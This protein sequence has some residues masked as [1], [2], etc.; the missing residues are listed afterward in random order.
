MNLLPAKQPDY[1]LMATI[2]ILLSF[3][4]IMVFSSSYIMAYKW[5]GDSFYFFN[6]QLFSALI[7]LAVFFITMKIDY[8]FW[9]KFAIPILIVSILLLLLLYVPGFQICQGCPKMV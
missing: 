4:I 2:L 8:R 9:R 5:Y 6:R 1:I 7:A 3:G